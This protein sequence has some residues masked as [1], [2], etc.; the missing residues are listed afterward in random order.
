MGRVAR[1][2]PSVKRVLHPGAESR[3]HPPLVTGFDHILS[4]ERAGRSIET[5]GRAASERPLPGV[6]TALVT[7]L[8]LLPLALGAD[9]AGREMEGPTAIVVLGGLVT[10]TLLNLLLL[11]A[12]S[13][14]FGNFT[15]RAAGEIRAGPKGATGGRDN[16][17]VT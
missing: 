11:P 7:G 3:I 12:I 13:W 5:G 8:G 15:P 10:S 2:S 16:S 14:R 9:E 6:I 4:V 1:V 17:P